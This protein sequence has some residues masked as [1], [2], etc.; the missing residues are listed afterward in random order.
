MVHCLGW[1][2]IISPE[3]RTKKQLPLGEM[4]QFDLRIF[5]NWVGSTT[6]GSVSYINDP[7]PGVNFKVPWSLECFFSVCSSELAKGGYSKWVLPSKKAHRVGRCVV[8]VVYLCFAILADF[9]V[10]IHPIGRAFVSSGLNR[11]L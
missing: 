10:E 4:V 8:G 7:D 9:F 1:C 11:E 5:F 6:N 3:K 2:R